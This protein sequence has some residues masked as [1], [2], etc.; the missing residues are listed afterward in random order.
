MFKNHILY[1]IVHEI[2]KYNGKGGSKWKSCP[3]L[4][5]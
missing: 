5:L 4:Y 3:A 1:G 2:I